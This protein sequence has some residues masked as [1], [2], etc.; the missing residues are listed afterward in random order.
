MWEIRSKVCYRLGNSHRVLTYSIFRNFIFLFIIWTLLFVCQLRERKDRKFVSLSR[1][2]PIVSIKLDCSR[3]CRRRRFFPVVV[4]RGVCSPLFFFL[5]PRWCSPH[6]G[7]SSVRFEKEMS[8]MKDRQ[9][10][11][12]V[13]SNKSAIHWLDDGHQNT[14]PWWLV[15]YYPNPF[16][17]FPSSQ[18]VGEK[19]K[20]S[21]ANRWKGTSVAFFIRASRPAK[22]FSL[23]FLFGIDTADC[24]GTTC[25]RGKNI[26]INEN[27][28]GGPFFQQLILGSSRHTPWTR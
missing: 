21:T 28:N 26:K 15:N 8:K 25:F 17:Y 10:R 19:K 3:G 7:D 24:F 18:Q 27:K 11:K 1:W 16:L 13:A 6:E 20:D 9:K 5:W 14:D 12:N 23:F 4:K 22:A 2:M